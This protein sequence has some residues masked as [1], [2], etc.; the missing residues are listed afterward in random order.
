MIVVGV[1]AGIVVVVFDIVVLLGMKSLTLQLIFHMTQTLLRVPT[2]ILMML[3]T[4]PDLLS[5]LKS[6]ILGDPLEFVGFILDPSTQPDVIKISQESGQEHI[7]PLFRVSRAFIWSMHKNRL[8][9]LGL[10]KYL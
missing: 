5:C 9:L 6:A 7:W 1:V 2:I 3:S 8:K 10:E 4:F